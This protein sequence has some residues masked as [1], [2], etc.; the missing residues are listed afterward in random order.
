MSELHKKVFTAGDK[1][2]DIACRFGI[3]RSTVYNILKLQ[4]ESGGFKR[5][6]KNAGRPKSVRTMN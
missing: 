3:A 2:T 5:H 4:N 6:S 1:P